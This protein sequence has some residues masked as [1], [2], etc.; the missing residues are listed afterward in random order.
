MSADYERTLHILL[1]PFGM[2]LVTG[3]TGSGKSTTL[4]AM[5]SRVGAERRNIVNISTVEDPVEYTLPRVNQV[6]INPN[7][8]MAFSSALHTLLRQDP[9]IIMVGEIRDLETAEIAVRAALVGRLLLSTLHTNDA[10]GAVPR[11]V[12][13]GVEPYLLASTLTLVVGQRLVRRIC[14]N[15]R[16][17]VPAEGAAWDALR[18]RPDFEELIHALQRQGALAKGANP[19]AGIRLFKGK[20]C[21]QCGSTGFRGRLGIFELFEIDDEIRHMMTKCEDAMTIRAAAMASGMK[22]L[23]QDGLAKALLGQ[24]TLEEVFRVAL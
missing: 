17:S 19:L 3:P 9:D 21:I 4:Y 18:S 16:E 11:L 13:M 5:L 12:D 14:P 6:S 1:R 2:I 23:F 10:T 7:A 22:T 24:T 15:C 20:G 8:G